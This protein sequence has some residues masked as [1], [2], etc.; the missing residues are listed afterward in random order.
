MKQH[1]APG[2]M[3]I[4]AL[5]IAGAMLGNSALLTTGVLAQ[6]IRFEHYTSEDG[7]PT[8]RLY[9]ATEA[10]DGYL[11]IGSQA[12]LTRFDG[13][14]F[15]SRL[16]GR[17]DELAL[18][19][20]SVQAVL[21]DSKGR[22]WVGTESG[23]V[24]EVDNN[25][26]S[27]RHYTTTTEVLQL[28]NSTIWSMAEDCQGNILLGFPGDGVARLNPEK[29][30]LDR[31]PMP[32]P[33]ATSESRLI[34]SLHVDR[35]CRIWAGLFRQGIM[36]MEQTG[37]QFV[38]ATEND[39]TVNNKAILSI[40]SDGDT[41]YAAG[42]NELGIFNSRTTEFSSS[43]DIASL[44]N[45]E[46]VGI[47]SISIN[48]DTLWAAT[49][50]GLY[51]IQLSGGTSPGN[52]TTTDR[53]AQPDTGLS[54]NFP[55]K[56]YQ[57]QQA[58]TGTLASNS[59]SAV[60]TGATGNVWIV[61]RDNGLIYKPPGWDNFNLIRRNPLKDNH[62]PSNNIIINYT[63][64]DFLWMGTFD[65]GLARYGYLDNT[66]STPESLK[67][68]PFQ[69]VWAIHIDQSGDLWL[70]GNR[71]V[72]RTS[73]GESPVQVSPPEHITQAMSGNRPMG[74]VELEDA[75]WLLGKYRY[76]LRFDKQQHSWTLHEPENTQESVTFSHYLPVND[77]Q[78]LV[79]GE[80]HLYRYDSQSGQFEVIL[81][82]GQDHIQQM[83]FDRNG[84]LWLARKSGFFQYRMDNPLTQTLQ[85][86]YPPELLNAVINNLLFD[87]QDKLWF[88][89]TNGLFKLLPDINDLNNQNDPDFLQLTR[90]DGLPSNE[91]SGNTLV[92]LNDGRM[93][94][95][96]NQ[97]Q[98]L[99]DPSKISPKDGRPRID[100]NNLSTLEH[101]FS[102]ELLTTRLP[103]FEHD[104]NTVSV[105]FNAVTFNNRDQ[106]SYQYRLDGWDNDW[107]NTSQAPQVTYSRL[108]HGQYTF[109]ARARIGSGDWG[110]INDSVT[111]SIQRPP[112]LTWWA[113][114]LY[115]AVALLLLALLQLRRRQAQQRRRALFQARERQQFAETQTRIATDFASAIHYEEIA[116]A[117]SATLKESMLMVRMLV[118]FQDSEQSAHEFVY[119]DHWAQQFSDDVN[120]NELYTGFENNPTMRYHQQKI[121]LQDPQFSAV[122][123]SLPLGAKRPAQAIACLHFPP[124]APPGENDIGLA[125]LVAQMAETA[126]HNTVLLEQVSQLAA[127]NQRANDAK[128]EFISTVSHEIRTPLH[129]LMGMLDLLN[130]CE[131]DR[132]RMNILHRLTDSSEQLLAVV[133]DV[134]DIS[135]I[136]ANKVE[137]HQDTF[138]LS[139]VLEHVTQLFSDQASAKNLVIY[140]LTAPGTCGWWLGDKTRLIQILTNLI[141]NAIKFTER[142][143]IYISIT[144]NR[145]T[146]SPG[147]QLQVAD[148]GMGME[149]D[150]L[151]RLFDEYQQAE[152]WTWKKYGGS[153]LGLSITKRLVE[154]MEGQIE[155]SS[156]VGKGSKFD[157][158]LPLEK[159]AIL[160]SI[161]PLPW[162]DNFVVHLAC[163]YTN[164]ILKVLLSQSNQVICH[165]D[166]SAVQLLQTDSHNEILITTSAELAQQCSMES[167]WLC[168]TDED[169]QQ[170]SSD[171]GIRT[172]R[173]SKDWS[174]LL[175]WLMARA[176]AGRE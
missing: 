77:R 73:P 174:L 45:T 50:T 109:N 28:P 142:G 79:S 122:Q 74:F 97:G 19:G 87:A 143:G 83:T 55:V 30:T 17:N 153:G 75:L 126:V 8:N 11:W 3:M 119:D 22:I 60:T 125:S 53:Q 154:L 69:R 10:Q 102:A 152:D 132:Q 62:I 65:A 117:L 7:L 81:D 42:T 95:G 151:D 56:H 148:T 66:F 34:A 27:V 164:D 130:Q 112:W 54:S 13:L 49:G 162:P 145:S 4:R 23:G 114:T 71:E 104:D 90:S 176:I 38:P 105:R 82:A 101:D 67:T 1:S 100:I 92:Q 39:W 94:I 25:L 118:H 141:N 169:Y 91:M 58:L 106:L 21:V 108:R 43:I 85:L 147:L 78:F 120:F 14:S 171:T 57:H 46:R 6:D 161:Q 16:H 47:N 29:E 155:V 48:A 72:L 24:V 44:L 149:A 111:F 137:L 99:F 80:S 70:A 123:L 86:E 26:N 129:G 89:S 146:D 107:I 144:E 173:L 170:L 35:N 33:S 150:V 18:P 2:K 41:I 61:S 160:S 131:S 167:A 68:L 59:L 37:K 134:L 113:Y 9:A 98:V 133:D 138:E 158:F 51:S 63:S 88:G 32:I 121:E 20:R 159:P 165:S 84:N 31:L 124:D 172:F 110:E 156:E 52:N 135:K 157:I 115:G 168:F 140:G 12:G 64:P 96:T 36:H 116:S 128:S 163:G 93:A 139:D 40:A 136:E 127:L 175:V 76:L 15:Q 166:Q 103:P 5:I